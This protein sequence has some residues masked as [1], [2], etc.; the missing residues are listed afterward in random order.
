[1]PAEFQKAI[2]CTLA[3]LTNLF[4]FSDDILTVSR[5]RNEN[6]LDLVR[7]CLIHLDQENLPINLAKCHSAKD[8]IEWLGHI[9]NQTGSIPLSNITEAI[10]KLSSHSNLKKLRSFIGSVHHLGKSV[11]HGAVELFW[12]RATSDPPIRQTKCK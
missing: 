6:H 2:D 10:E 9:I 8:K 11:R 7:K 3:G 1:M 12:E 5:G 4:C